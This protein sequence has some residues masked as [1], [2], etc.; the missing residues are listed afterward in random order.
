[1]TLRELQSEICA[2]GFDRCAELNSSL[3]YSARRALGE[4]SREARIV[5][6]T[7]LF[8]SRPRPS[9]SI[10]VFH[11]TGGRTEL[12]PLKGYAFTLCASGKGRIAVFDG[13]VRKN[14][15]FDAES[16]IIKGIIRGEGS[17]EFA[18]EYSYDVFGITVYSEP[19]FAD[20]D[21]IPSAPCDN[22]VDMRDRV[23]DF[24]EFTGE[25]T[26]TAGN[27]GR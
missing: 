10:K 9:S 8:A 15:T 24:L 4:I 19:Y 27:P 17:L 26:D 13:N 21:D 23:G 25:I 11:H 6:R 12:L 16:K 1:M 14:I 5:C 18:G 22:S 20:C 3:L 2:L 7:N